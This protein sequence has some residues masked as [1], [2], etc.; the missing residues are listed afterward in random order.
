MGKCSSGNPGRFKMR[1][2]KAPSACRREDSS[3]AGR[4]N[5]PFIRMF[6]CDILT[7][8]VT[9]KSSGRWRVMLYFNQKGKG[10]R[11]TS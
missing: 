1:Q 6:I 2:G 11:P 3:T 7:G 10:V 8:K 5:E 9:A 4:Q